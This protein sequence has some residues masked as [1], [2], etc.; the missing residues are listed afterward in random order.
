M[1]LFAPVLALLSLV[2]ATPLPDADAAPSP[3]T[4]DGPRPTTP[5][6]GPKWP[7]PKAG[8]CGPIVCVRAPCLNSCCREFLAI[9]AHRS[10]WQALLPAWVDVH[11]VQRSRGLLPA[12][13]V[14]P[15]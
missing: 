3:I 13:L 9:N 11:E 7:Q 1:K 8:K 5:Y 12:Q 15:C 6:D 4:G 10:F 14:L 2:T